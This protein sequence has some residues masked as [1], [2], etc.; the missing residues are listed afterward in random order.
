MR[1]GDYEIMRSNQW[2]YQ[3]Y[4]VMPEGFDNSRSKYRESE[5]GRALKP[6]ECYPNDLT[7]GHSP[8]Y[9]LLGGRR[10]RMRG[11]PRRAG[12]SGGGS[13]RAGCA[14]RPIQRGGAVSDLKDKIVFLIAAA[15]TALIF[16]G[17]AVLM[18]A[19]VARMI[20][21]L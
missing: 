18:L 7:A 4:R 5:D 1:F 3:L 8:R 17:G 11:R 12:A 19:F 13:R 14:R 16:I 10:G 21:G 9:R 6:L 20:W 2:C 15:V